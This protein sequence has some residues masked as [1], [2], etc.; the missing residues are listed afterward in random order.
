MQHYKL[1]INGQF[2]ESSS[3][4]TFETVDP[5]TEQPWATIAE[6]GKD[7]VN[8]AVNSAYD[9]FYGDWSKVLPNQRGHFLKFSNI[10]YIYLTLYF[11]LLKSKVYQPVIIYLISVLLTTPR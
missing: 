10:T 7:D 9:A 1:Y 8:Y 6:A 5:S 4:N 2:V 11:P 3:K